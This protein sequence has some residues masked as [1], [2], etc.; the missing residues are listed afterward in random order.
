MLPDDW[1]MG[2]LA[3]VIQRDRKITYGIV[4]PGGFVEIGVALVRGGD[5]STGWVSLDQIKRVRPEIDAPYKR[6]R[7]KGGD[8]LLTI[9][10]ANTGTVAVVPSWLEGANITQTTARIAVDV[11]KA[12]P[13]FVAHVLKSDWG[14]EEVR[15]YVKGAAQPGLNLEDLA[16]FLLP[17]PPLPEQRRIGALLDAWDTAVATADL[18]VEAKRARFGWIRD[19]VLSG[20]KRLRG[21][22][23]VWRTVRLAEILREHGLRSDRTEPVF[24]VS[25]HKGLIDQVEHLGRSFSAADTAHYNRVLPGDIVYTKSPTGFFPLGIIKQSKIDHSVI[26]SPLYGV[27]TPDSAELGLVLDAYFSSPKAVEKY[28]TPLVQ[29]GAKNTIAVT[30]NQFLQGVISI[31]NDKSELVELADLIEASL[32]EIAVAESEAR[33]FRQ[34]RRGLMQLLLTGKLRVPASIDRLLPD[35]QV[36]LVA[37]E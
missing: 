21:H 22:N 3:S 29:K 6:S 4:Q 2:P 37:A 36:E 34:Q 10:G 19:Q 25:V 15:K 14:Q 23:N 17:Q 24:S 18:L 33:L 26:V 11:A 9:V 30:N 8:L 35:A 13:S 1:T 12:D 31:P 16:S 32:E 27:F 20:K 5:Y 7:L 28:V